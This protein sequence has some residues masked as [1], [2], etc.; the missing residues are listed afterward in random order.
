MSFSR[1]LSSTVARHVLLCSITVT[2]LSTV[3]FGDDPKK[4]VDEKYSF[5]LSVPSP[6][7]EA[8]LTSY[9]VPGTVRAAW[10]G[11]DNASLLAFVQEPGKAF[12]PRF[13]VDESAKAMRGA[14]WLRDS[15]QRSQDGQR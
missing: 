10:S 5:S 2:A 7:A 12:S 8:P 4:Y 13:L 14:A 1:T 11:K 15:G 6:W 3:A 9:T